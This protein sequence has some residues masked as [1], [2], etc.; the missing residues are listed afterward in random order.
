MFNYFS[1]VDRAYKIYFQI[2]ADI[3]LI[4]FSLFIARFLLNDNPIDVL[5][6]F[7]LKNFYLL[8]FFTILINYS[9]RIYQT[10]VRA[11]IGKSLLYFIIPIFASALIVFSLYINL[12][13]F[14]VSDKQLN[15]FKKN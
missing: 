3:C 10:P 13:I 14:Y 5:K 1:K 2:F 12:G 7:F 15:I 4:L 9:F 11:I 6:I 8:I